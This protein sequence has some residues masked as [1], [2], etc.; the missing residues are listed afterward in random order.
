LPLFYLNIDSAPSQNL[1]KTDAIIV[2]T[3]SSERIPEGIILLNQS[4]A[5][6]LLISGVGMDTTTPELLKVLELG[7]AELAKIDIS[8]ISLGYTAT[9]TVGNAKESASW[10]EKNQ[11]KSI[12]LVTS[13]YHIQRAK[14]E[15]KKLMPNL[16]IIEHPTFP[17]DFNK[18]EWRTNKQVRDLII[19]EYFKYLYSW[20]ASFF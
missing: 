2:L 17:A 4:L 15:F 7:F 19:R 8:G 3:G 13:N 11:I 5:S 20:A 9:D 18:K 10:I 12:R 16:I 6:R 14:L 1:Q